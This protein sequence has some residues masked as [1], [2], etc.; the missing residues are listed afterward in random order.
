MEE[1]GL[2]E[3]IELILENEIIKRRGGANIKC[4][5]YK[6]NSV[7]F[8]RDVFDFEFRLEKN[9]EIVD[10]PENYILEYQNLDLLIKLYGS[11]S[12]SEEL[13]IYFI[14]LL[15]NYWNHQTAGY[16]TTETLIKLGY[17]KR[18]IPYIVPSN[19][20]KL[21]PIII[22]I[23]ELL[24]YEYTIFSK[25]ELKDINKRFSNLTHPGGFT[26]KDLDSNAKLLF[27]INLSLLRIHKI[28]Y[29]ALARTLTQGTN[30]EIN[31]DRKKIQE[32]IQLFGFDKILSDALDKIEEIYW[33][34][35]TDK[36]DNS[37]AIDKLR[38]FWEK[39]VESI[40]EKIKEKTKEEFPKTEKTI[41]GNYRVYMKKHLDLD[42][43][44]ELINKLVDILNH[45]GSHNF[46]SEREYF[47]LTKNITIEI[48][49][50]IFTKLE[51]LM[52]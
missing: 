29:D 15:M 27:Y 34:N 16:L 4:Y 35:S 42:E 1:I 31:A 12:Y 10:N 48:S 40:C 33:S 11:I 2:K 49:L 20:P 51:L 46:I 22:T 44:N 24:T 8:T 32:K 23:D 9:G 25:E 39:T 43:E 52:K 36:F 6:D 28:L 45:K 38:T 21:S 14:N 41:M 3:K 17:L 37:M 18:I 13:K 30:Y 47:R 50:L 19:I 26:K 7:T 5:R